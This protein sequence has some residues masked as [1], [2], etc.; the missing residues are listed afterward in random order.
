MFIMTKDEVKEEVNKINCYLG[1]CLWMD[2]EI[3]QMSFIRIVDSGRIDTSVNRFSIDIE[4]EEPHCISSLMSWHLDDNLP[5]IELATEEEI[6][7]NKRYRVEL[8]NYYFKINAEDF[9]N[10]PIYIA[11]KKITCKILEENPFKRKK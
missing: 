8:G 3:C 6:M 10:P 1:K 9:E 7:M 2:F 4:F 11:A 5:F